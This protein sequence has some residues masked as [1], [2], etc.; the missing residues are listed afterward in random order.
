LPPL[1]QALARFREKAG[2][3]PLNVQ[4]ASETEGQKHGQAFYVNNTTVRR[5]EKGGK[6]SPQ[7]LL[8]L[9][10]I[11]G[12]PISEFFKA[13]GATDSEICGHELTLEEKECLEM[14][15]SEN[16]DYFRKLKIVLEMK[17]ETLRN[18]VLMAID[19][20]LSTMK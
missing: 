4:T 12:V 7:K 15:R 3:N 5:Y 8:T 6:P 11:Y 16:A 17:N 19:G 10:R 13:I 14:L 9:A 20:A 2:L 1:A 18:A